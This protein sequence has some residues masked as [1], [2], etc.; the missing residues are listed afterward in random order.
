MILLMYRPDDFARHYHWPNTHLPSAT[1]V[2]T[3]IQTAVPGKFVLESIEDHGI[4]KIFTV[5]EN[6]IRWLPIAPADYPRTLREWGRFVHAPFP[7]TD[8]C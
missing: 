1:W 7:N 3:A 8:P 2:A 6:E 5:C 4:R